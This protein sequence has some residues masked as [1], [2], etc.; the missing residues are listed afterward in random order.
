MSKA[1]APG[2][3]QIRN[4]ITGDTYIGSSHNMGFRWETHVH[5]LQAHRHRNKRLQAAWDEYGEAAFSF[6]VLE[7]VG[8]VSCLREREQWHLCTLKPV[9]NVTGIRQTTPVKRR[10]HAPIQ[11]PGYSRVADVCTQRNVS[12]HVMYRWIR[13]GM[14]QPFKAPGVRGIYLKD[15]EVER[16][17][18]PYVK[19]QRI[20][21]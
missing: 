7:H 19:P 3:Y 10:P 13:E 8:D 1:I 14:L 21:V 2:I 17:F 16:F 15:D 11:C 9:Y 18:Q 5:D 6:E 4:L 20:T 12:P